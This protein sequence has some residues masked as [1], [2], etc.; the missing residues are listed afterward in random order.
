MNDA[1][2]ALLRLVFWSS[3][4]LLGLVLL[5]IVLLLSSTARVVVVVALLVVAVL[6]GPELVRWV[7]H[8]AR[9]RN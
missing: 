7:W 8:R 3:V 2:S 5:G 1:G 9:R 4:T 6:W